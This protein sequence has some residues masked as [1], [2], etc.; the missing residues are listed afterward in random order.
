MLLIFIYCLLILGLNYN[1]MYITAKKITKSQKATQS[2]KY[3]NLY[4]FF[5]FI[6]IMV[7][8]I[9]IIIL[10]YAYIKSITNPTSS[11]KFMFL[12][13]ISFVFFVYSN[14]AL[15]VSGKTMNKFHPK[16]E[17]ALF[18]RGFGSDNY[19]I[20]SEWDALIDDFR[21]WQHK[22]KIDPQTQPF[23]EELFCAAIKKHMPIYSVG[24]TSEVTSPIGSKRIYLDDKTWKEDVSK[25]IK[26]AKLVFVLLHNSESCMWE[27]L[28]CDKEA[29]QKTIYFVEDNDGFKKILKLLKG[30][31]PMLL[32]S[33]SSI[34][35]D[36]GERV[37]ST[38]INNMGI[39]PDNI[40]FDKLNRETKK[41][42]DSIFKA[43]SKSGISLDDSKKVEIIEAFINYTAKLHRVLYF[44]GKENWVMEY[45]N[46]E[47][48]FAKMLK[49]IFEDR[50]KNGT[51]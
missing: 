36:I 31:A 7:F 47:A 48:G 44:D 51:V 30:S 27:I 11:T 10:M 40:D 9:G 2:V 12:L 41:Q 4:R 37:R 13:I 29:P 32:S 16:K 1:L 22:E 23:S 5:R 34:I 26:K 8:T 14:L 19:D 20:G 39:T 17:Y 49:V 24:M 33:Q 38:V 18:L 45:E 42:L 28:Q 21:P 46:T 6:L 50:R 15:P 25:L 3:R 35:E 43:V